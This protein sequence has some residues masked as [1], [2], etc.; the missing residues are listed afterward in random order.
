VARRKKRQRGESLPRRIA[1]I[2]GQ[3]G[4]VYRHWGRGIF[5]LAVVVFV[6]LGLIDAAFGQIDTNA[7]DPGDGFTVAA[8]LAATGA[9]TATGLLGEVFF[10]GAIA[11]SL[12]HPEG[13]RPPPLRH[14][15]G[16]L[17]Y[18]RL[19]AIDIL[20][21][22]IVATGLVLLVVPGIVAFV[23]LCLAGPA[24]ELEDHGVRAALKRSYR[25]VRSDFWLVF[26]VIVPIE[27]AGD[28]LGEAFEHLL[29]HEFGDTFF[30]AWIAESVSNAILSPLFAVGAVLIAV[31]LI[32]EMDGVGPRLRSLAP[33]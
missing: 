30:T 5:V 28:A 22:L 6:P 8:A 23:L 20:Y 3:I 27:I 4:R 9:V 31:R 29:H 2:Y 15:A 21:V 19:I 33:R 12:T 7:R 17:N 14:I 32:T 13:D 26:W 1:T 25:L 18:K 24:V 11:V 10:A 16:H